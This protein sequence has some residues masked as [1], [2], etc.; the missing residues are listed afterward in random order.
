[1][2]FTFGKA[3]MKELIYGLKNSK[4]SNPAVIGAFIRLGNCLDLL[5]TAKIEYLRLG[6]EILE[7][8]ANKLEVALPQNKSFHL[9]Y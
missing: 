7:Q 9:R 5:D 3:A 2:V 1:M 4:V 6:Y 8:E